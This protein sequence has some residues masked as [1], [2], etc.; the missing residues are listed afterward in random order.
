LLGGKD[1]TVL[2]EDWISNPDKR[3]RARLRALQS[4]EV[5]RQRAA[6]YGILARDRQGDLLGVAIAGGILRVL[7]LASQYCITPAEVVRKARSAAGAL[8]AHTND[9]IAT[10]LEVFRFDGSPDGLGC[11][12]AGGLQKLEELT[13]AARNAAVQAA[14]ALGALANNVIATALEVFRPDGSPDGLG[15]AIAGG[16]NVLEP[17]CVAQR[18]AVVA[19][20]RSEAGKLGGAASS[21]VCQRAAEAFEIILVS[22]KGD[23]LGYAIAG[24]LNVLEPLCVAQRL[25]VVA[26]A[27]SE[28]IKAG[29]A[30]CERAAKALGILD[31]AGNGDV[32]AF[33]SAGGL[34]RL[35]HLSLQ[36]RIEA[37][38]QAKRTNSAAGNQA[39]QDDRKVCDFNCMFDSN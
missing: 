15:C 6:H 13:V 17:L 8:G 21:E 31:G 1:V 32:V 24:G 10:A 37:A 30:A 38:E 9:V 3:A 16:L 19:K 2:M 5:C 25:A 14:R 18:L 27:R 22:G 7:A 33:C 34:A 4:A 39:T 23:G 35:E 28:A 11:A 29:N 12:I 20:A 26:K 36:E